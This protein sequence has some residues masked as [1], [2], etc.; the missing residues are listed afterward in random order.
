MSIVRMKNKKNGVVYV[1]DSTSYWDKKKRQ[2]RNTR[3]CIG[4][5]DPQTDKIIYN[6]TSAEKVTEKAY[7]PLWIQTFYYKLTGEV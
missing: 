1:Y 4:K 2:A 6:G 3:V 7:I 5:I